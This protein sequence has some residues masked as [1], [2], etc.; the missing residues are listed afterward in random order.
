M[1][2]VK[3][4]DEQR[5]L[6]QALQLFWENGFEAT[7][8]SDLTN[9]LGI[10]KGSFYD[11]FGSKRMLFDKCL[12]MYQS[13]SME[14]LDS[15]LS[16]KED[17]VDAIG[18]LLDKHTQMMLMDSGAKGCFIANSTSELADDGQVREF[19]IKHNQLMRDKIKALFID[20]PY[21]ENADVIA[22]L[23]LTHITGISV[24]SKFVRNPDRFQS[25][26]EIFM[27]IFAV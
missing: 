16:E 2:R 10:G 5:A 17:P 3:L 15:I 19:L 14:T 8:L 24:M 12:S 25:S 27:K 13:I 22:D 11:T 1:P 4:F 26:N 20:S 18:N 21:A 6:G 7:S 23:V 9:E